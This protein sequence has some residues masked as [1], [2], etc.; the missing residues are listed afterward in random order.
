MH[1]DKEQNQSGEKDDIPDKEI[2][3]FLGETD[4]EIILQM[5][6]R[7]DENEALKKLIE[8][9]NSTITSTKSKKNV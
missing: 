5:K 2:Y 6:K 8:N 4:K 7:K 3:K 9:L 1:K